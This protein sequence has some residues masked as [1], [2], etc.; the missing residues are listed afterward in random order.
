MQCQVCG[1]PAKV[2]VTEVS[3][4]KAIERRLCE[5]CGKKEGCANH[6]KVRL[7]DLLGKTL[8]LHGK[9]IAQMET[10]RDNAAPADREAT[11]EWLESAVDH[12]MKWEADWSKLLHEAQKA[13]K[14]D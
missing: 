3:R 12:H 11:R 13:A 14:P 7:L 10:R 1:K 2:F 6:D 9:L 5:L 4:G 8:D